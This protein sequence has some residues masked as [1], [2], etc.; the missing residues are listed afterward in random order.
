MKKTEMATVQEGDKIVNA[1][2][3]LSK[4]KDFNPDTFEKLINLQSK[5][6]A[7]QQ[8]EAFSES[9]SKFQAECPI[10]KKTK[11]VNYGQTN[12]D[13]ASLDEMVHTIKPILGKHGLSFAFDTRKED[14][15]MVLVTKVK[16]SQGH[17]EHFEFYFSAMDDGGKMNNSQRRKSAI[18]YAKRSALENALG[19]VTAGEDDDAR[20]AIDNPATEEQLTKIN[21]LLKST[22]TPLGQFLTYL[23][24]E[25]LD[26]LSVVDAKKALN[27]LNSKRNALV[28]KEGK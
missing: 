9:F 17:E 22:D 10:I 3:E 21:S 16:H 6:K 23:K 11:K 2:A 14:G 7:E 19:L 12:Y 15:E 24:I 20:R 26:M 13:Y 18:T 4:Q 8:R 5:M 25:S 28:S 27:L 1:I